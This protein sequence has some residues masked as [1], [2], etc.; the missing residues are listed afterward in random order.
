MGILI[1]LFVA[2][3]CGCVIAG[4]GIWVEAF[5]PKRFVRATFRAGWPLALRVRDIPDFPVNVPLP[6]SATTS[7]GRFRIPDSGI[8]LFHRVGSLDRWSTSFPLA[9][10]IR[11]QGQETT[12]V[13]RVGLASCC[14]MACW[15]AMPATMAILVLLAEDR[16]AAMVGVVAMLGFIAFGVILW[17][18]CVRYERNRAEEVAREVADAI[19]ILS[20]TKP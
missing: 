13:A 16:T 2:F 20:R 8:C 14:F 10:T 9:G 17:G 19:R 18:G 6:Y 3:W 11:W 4:A 15:L 12:V 5:R 1:F 7:H